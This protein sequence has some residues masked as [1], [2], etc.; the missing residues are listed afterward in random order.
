[1][2]LLL[3][4]VLRRKI[5]FTLA[6]SK[7]SPRHLL[8]L[9]RGL[10]ALLACNFRPPLVT[11]TAACGMSQSARLACSKLGFKIVLLPF[12][13]KIRDV[14]PKESVSV[15]VTLFPL[16]NDLSGVLIEISHKLEV[17]LALDDVK[18]PPDV[19]DCEQLAEV[20]GQG[21]LDM[22]SQRGL[23]ACKNHKRTRRR[24]PTLLQVMSV[25]NAGDAVKD[26]RICGQISGVKHTLHT[27]A[28]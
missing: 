19:L 1:L 2:L 11:S 9:H 25:C 7:E 24:V 20:D 12:V 5:P 14:R 13:D 28:L 4:L 6:S 23:S 17:F 3:L 27:R 8:N 15:A 16:C 18:R 26:S 10:V 22:I 21:Y